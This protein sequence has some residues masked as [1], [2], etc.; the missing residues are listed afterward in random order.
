MGGHRGHGVEVEPAWRAGAGEEHTR[1]RD[2]GCRGNRAA[3]SWLVCRTE[4]KRTE[5]KKVSRCAGASGRVVGVQ[6]GLG[7]GLGKAVQCVRQDAAGHGEVLRF[8]CQSAGGHWKGKKDTIGLILQDCPWGS[9]KKGWERI[10]VR[11]G[12]SGA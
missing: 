12:A 10:R 3:R 11:V 6:R 2:S 5:K 9:E 7:L 1:G 4:R 8:S